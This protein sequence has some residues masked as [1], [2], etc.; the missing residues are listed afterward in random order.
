M[1][2]CADYIKATNAAL[3]LIKNLSYLIPPI[4]PAKIATEIAVEVYFAEFTGNYTNVSGFFDA[5]NN[6][7][8]VNKAESPT[9]QAFT[10]AHELGHKIL[11]EEWAKSNDYKFLL[12]EKL[13]LPSKDWHEQEANTFAANLLV[14]EKMLSKYRNIASIGEL[15]RLFSVSESVIRNRLK[16]VDNILPCNK[17]NI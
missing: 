10:I 2:K 9:R 5:F 12:R 8:Y 14:P 17:C 1:N 7:I 4:N 13:E 6:K 15:A 16:F 3:E 11:H